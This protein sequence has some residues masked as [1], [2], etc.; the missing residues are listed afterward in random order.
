[1]G[2]LRRGDLAANP[3]E[4]FGAWFADAGATVETPEA[5]AIYG[6][7]TRALTQESSIRR[8]AAVYGA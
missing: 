4:Q 8:D 6:T 1:M 7:L 3:L 2:E 5:T